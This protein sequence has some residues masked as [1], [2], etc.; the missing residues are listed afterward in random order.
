VLGL[1]WEDL[2]LDAAGTAMVQRA[3]V[4]IDGAGGR[5]QQLGSTEADGA[6]GE[7]WLM[8]TVV[9]LFEITRE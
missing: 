5:G 2:D 9:E 3:S 1:A 8:P 6:R 7:Q 4:Y